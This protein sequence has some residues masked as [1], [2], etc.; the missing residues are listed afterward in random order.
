MWVILELHENCQMDRCA[1]ALASEIKNAFGDKVDYFIPVHVE[2]ING[3][4]LVTTLFE[5]Y[6]FVDVSKC[7]NV[8]KCIESAKGSYI[9][10]PIVNRGAYTS[11]TKEEIDRYRERLQS[12][13][14]TWVPRLK[15][16]VVPKMGVF[17]NLVG[18]VVDVDLDNKTATIVFSTRS[19]EV[20][21]NIKLLNLLPKAEAE[22]L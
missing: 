20:T 8:S 19:R 5:G 17:R 10:G 3:K 6:V 21:T 22:R 2:C 7:K 13:L 16:L 9:A 4:R 1:D 11:V 18:R 15:D 12:S 14:Y